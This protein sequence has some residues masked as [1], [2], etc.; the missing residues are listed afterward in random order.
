MTPKTN[1]KSVIKSAGQRENNDDTDIYP[2]APFSK[3]PRRVET[4]KLTCA[5]SQWTDLYMVWLLMLEGIFEQTVRPQFV[6]AFQCDCYLQCAIYFGL[7]DGQYIDCFSN[8]GESLGCFHY[9]H[10]KVCS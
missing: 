3:D 10:A 9:F 7:G 2:E 5:T 6:E 1:T 8:I 4:S